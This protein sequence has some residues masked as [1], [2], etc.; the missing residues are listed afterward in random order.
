LAVTTIDNLA[1]VLSNE[2]SPVSGGRKRISEFISG[3]RL[4]G[5]LIL[6]DYPLL[7]LELLIFAVINILVFFSR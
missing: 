3:H 1:T 5:H 7:F 4:Q 6:R 2:T